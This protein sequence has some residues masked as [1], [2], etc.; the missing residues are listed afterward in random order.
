MAGQGGN[1]V[2][3]L[4]VL[5]GAGVAI[6]AGITDP[7][8]GVRE[9]IRRAI[10]GEPEQRRTRGVSLSATLASLT[11]PAPAP[12]GGG[13]FVST[14][15]NLGNVKPHVAAAAREIGG[16]FGVAEVGGFSYRNIA[17]TTSLSDHALGL[18]LDFMTTAGD[19]IAAYAMSNAA[20]LGVTYIIWD[21]RIWSVERAAEGWRPYYGVSPHT[22]HVHVSFSARGGAVSV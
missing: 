18:A 6:W 5:G 4:L 8:G 2:L 13:G 15:Y 7:E 9:G 17:G 11:G 10:G 21:R 19:G 14:K 1:L 3:S 20:R 16:R 22:D 12:S